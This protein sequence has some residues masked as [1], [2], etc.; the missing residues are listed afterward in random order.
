[1]AISFTL[2]VLEAIFNANPRFI[3]LRDDKGRTPLHIV[4]SLGYLEEA[5]YLLK[6]HALNATQ[7][8]K[9]G[10]FPIHLASHK[11]HVDVVRI[12]LHYLPDPSELLDR[13]GC[14]ILH[15]AAKSGRFNVCSFILNNPHME[16]LINMKDKF[17]NTPLHCA[18]RY[19]H[20]KIVNALTWD[21]RVDIKAVDNNRMSAL[22]V[23]ESVMQR[24]PQL[25]EV[26]TY[27]YF[28]IF[29]YYFD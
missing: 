26:R 15:V 4:A 10:S 22:D 3:Q 28:I 24:N 27:T 14:N 2:D 18:T 5:R 29:D 6:K 21:K 11:G 25:R 12:L 23:A 8:D 20:P 19:W 17:G 13:D 7:K 9:T 16:H 1:M